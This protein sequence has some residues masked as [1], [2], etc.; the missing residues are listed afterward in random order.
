MKRSRR[1]G[2]KEDSSPDDE[3]GTAEPSIVAGLQA[4]N[5]LFSF[6]NAPIEAD[7]SIKEF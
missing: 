4:K 5:S 6:S 2:F 3:W 1:G 7:S